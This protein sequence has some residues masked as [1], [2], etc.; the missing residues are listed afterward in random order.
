MPNSNILINILKQH[1]EFEVFVKDNPKYDI[2]IKEINL[3]EVKRIQKE[4]PEL[5]INHENPT[6]GLIGVTLVSQTIHQ[7]GYPKIK[8][9]INEKQQKIVKIFRSG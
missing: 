7:Q 8:A 2:Y 6:G 9:Y 3:V 4:Y 1:P 5:D